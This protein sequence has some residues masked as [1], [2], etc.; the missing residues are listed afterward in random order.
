MT[1]KNSASTIT[2][3]DQIVAVLAKMPIS[4]FGSPSV[5]RVAIQ[6]AASLNKAQGW[7]FSLPIKYFAKKAECAPR[8]VQRALQSLTKLQFFEV[9]YR[10]DPH[11]AKFNL[12]SVYRLGSALRS[13]C[14][15]LVTRGRSGDRGSLKPNKDR[16]TRKI[17]APANSVSQKPTR[18]P[19]G[20][21]KPSKAVGPTA[22]VRTPEEW[23]ARRL[24]GIAL[25]QESHKRAMAKMAAMMGGALPA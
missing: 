3:S 15:Q 2:H 23:E 6:I 9:E 12:S 4:T 16:P 19:Y 5:Q 14:E 11:D 22:T 1:A 20:P 13:I 8:T 24:E 21:S 7:A 25:A 10:K 17:P 18:K